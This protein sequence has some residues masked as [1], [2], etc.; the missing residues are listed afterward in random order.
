MM[1]RLCSYDHIK[2]ITQSYLVL[3][4][5]MNLIASKEQLYLKKTPSSTERGMPLCKVHHMKCANHV[6]CSNVK[7]GHLISSEEWT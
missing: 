7:K 3:Q 5:E 6:S 1:R 4:C 2:E